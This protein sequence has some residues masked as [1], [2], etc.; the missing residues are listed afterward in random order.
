M[1]A[2]AIDELSQ[3]RF[4]LGLGAS[5]KYWIENQMGIPYLQPLTAI[6]E[7]V[8]LMRGLLN[9]QQVTHKGKA[10]STGTVTLDR[11]P[12]RK[13]LPI[14]LGVKSERSLVL[15][16]QVADGVLLSVGSPVEYVRYAKNLIH[17]GALAAGRN[18]KDILI[19]AYLPIFVNANGSFARENM[20]TITAEFL[21]IH[22]EHPIL[23][24]AGITPAQIA[25]FREAYLSGLSC[26]RLVTDSLVNKLMI[27]GT[28]EE[29]LE[30]LR[31][32]LNAGLDMPIL[33]E[34]TG[35]DP[36]ESIKMIKANLM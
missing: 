30:R 35:V 21:G 11:K 29:C 17:Q 23:L 3:G 24:T 8:Q 18:P 25:P 20:R 5:N 16:G 6:K 15:A 33:F 22:G 36:L 7:S 10:F 31:D 4:I 13:C 27:A 19:A 14:F 1:E 28:A 9:S 26:E 34:S 2:I 32:Y 12:Y